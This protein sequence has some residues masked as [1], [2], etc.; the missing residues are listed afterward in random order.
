MVPP[1][2]LKVQLTAF[3]SFTLTH[4]HAYAQAHI[5]VHIYIYMLLFFEVSPRDGDMLFVLPY[6]AINLILMFTIEKI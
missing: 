4:M 3:L 5:H 6:S 1:S 2:H